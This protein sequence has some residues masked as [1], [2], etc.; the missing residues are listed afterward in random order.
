[1]ALSDTCLYAF[2]DRDRG[3]NGWMLALFFNHTAAHRSS[4]HKHLRY[5]I[6]TLSH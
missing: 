2:I 4:Q 3:Q 1:M 6:N 5:V